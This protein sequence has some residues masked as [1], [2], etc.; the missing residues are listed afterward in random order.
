[1]AGGSVPTSLLILIFL[2]VWA[3]P[4]PGST[5]RQYD[6][7]HTKDWRRIESEH[8]VLVGNASEGSMR[9][10]G[11]QLEQ[12]RAAV[13][14]VM[15]GYQDP[16]EPDTTVVVF[17]NEAAFRPFR[18]DDDVSGYFTSGPHRNYIALTGERETERTIYHEYIHQLTREARDWPVWL[19]EGT[20]EFYS[21][22]QVREGG[23][24]VRLGLTIPPHL[25]WLDQHF[26]PLEQFL[27][28]DASFVGEARTRTLYAHPS[29]SRESRLDVGTR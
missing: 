19:R 3:G 4:A 29:D 2:I 24:T 14:A 18:P 22:I 17:E 23:D 7:Q 15:P 12:F 27:D 10:V 25:V 16:H 5:R 9:R 21:T 20:A 6:P 11:Q 28:P 1:M 8:F 26:M 13:L